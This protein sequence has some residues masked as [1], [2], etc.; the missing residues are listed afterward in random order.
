MPVPPELVA[1][2]AA[3]VTEVNR[4]VS[5][6]ESIRRVRI[7]DGDFTLERGLLSTSLKVRREAVLQTYED[8]VEA[9]YT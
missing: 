8:D 1:E 3:A 7:V 4:S 2:V 6:A 9:L 5:R